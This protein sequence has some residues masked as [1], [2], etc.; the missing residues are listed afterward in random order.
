MPF[1]GGKLLHQNQIKAKVDLPGAG[2]NMPTPANLLT[3]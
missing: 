3:M 2:V 1:Q